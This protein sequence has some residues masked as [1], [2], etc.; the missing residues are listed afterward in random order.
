MVSLLLTGGDWKLTALVPEERVVFDPFPMFEEAPTEGSDMAWEAL[1]GRER[2]TNFERLGYEADCLA[3]LG[4]VALNHSEKYGL[5]PGDPKGPD[6][7]VYQLSVVHQIQ[8]LVGSLSPKVSRH[9]TYIL[10]I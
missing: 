5:P 1:L 10:S 2:D 3:S 7:H 4:L 8:C 6:T 9:I